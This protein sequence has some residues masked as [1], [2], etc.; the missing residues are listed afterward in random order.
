MHHQVMS[1]W[2]VYDHPVDRPD[3]YVARRFLIV[4][5]SE[6]IAT[7]DAL[8]SHYLSALRTEMLRRRLARIPRDPHDDPVIIESWI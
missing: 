5:K 2:T 6:P 1:V 4:G 7:P 3:C 8:R